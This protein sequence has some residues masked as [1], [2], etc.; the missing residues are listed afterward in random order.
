MPHRLQRQELYTG[1]LLVVPRMFFADNPGFVQVK[2]ATVLAT[3]PSPA[4]LLRPPPRPA[5]QPGASSQTVLRGA[6]AVAAPASA[7]GS[8]IPAAQPAAGPAAAAGSKADEADDD[9]DDFFAVP[10]AEAIK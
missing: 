2:S 4:A 10:D 6:A 1:H 3:S 8:S 5:V 7:T 9:G